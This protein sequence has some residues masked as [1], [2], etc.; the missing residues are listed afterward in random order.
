MKKI[1]LESNGSSILIVN[2]HVGEIV[3]TKWNPTKSMLASGGNSDCFVNL[4][5]T[6]ELSSSQSLNSNLLN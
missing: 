1:P 6:K 3:Y 5:D 2:E 4:W